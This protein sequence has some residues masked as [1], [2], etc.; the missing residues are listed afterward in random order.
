MVRG[1]ISRLDELTYVIT[2][3]PV[4]KWT[5]DYKKF[6]TEL[7]I[8]EKKTPVIADFKENHT[9]TTVHFTIILT[10]EQAKALEG[11]DLYKFFKLETSIKITNFN[12]FDEQ[13]HIHHYNSPEEILDSFFD[14]RYP[15]Y[16]VRKEHM[17]AKLEKETKRL[18]NMARFILAVVNE[19]LI[20]S[21]RPRK[22]I[23]K[24]L[25][26]MGYDTFYPEKAKTISSNQV[27][28][29]EEEEGLNE[30]FDEQTKDLSRGYN[31][32]L[33]LKIW[34]LTKEMVDKLQRELEECKEKLEILKNT[35]TKT[36]WENDLD[37]FVEELMKV[38]EKQN[39]YL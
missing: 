37:A 4:G 35:S 33:S 9:D 38:S 27:I 3:L 36:M 22:A 14:F 5:Q 26:D 12:L 6:L 21:N 30:Q 18:S 1:R 32:L 13:G 15:L 11:Q 16:Q 20:I 25:V 19:E 31:Y 28:S 7:A 34:S 8:P 24:D 2:E 17:I 29:L 23:M 39:F 10:P